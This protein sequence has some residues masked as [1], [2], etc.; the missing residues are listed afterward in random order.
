MNFI[1]QAFKGQFAFW[2]YIGFIGLFLIM[3]VGDTDNASLKIQSLIQQF[4]NNVTLLI[5][6]APF[7]ILLLFLF[8]W[9]KYIH[10]QPIKTLT[11]TRTKIDFKRILFA[12]CLW[13]GISLIMI[14]ISYI[15]D[16]ELIRLNFKLK[17]F[18]VLVLISVILIPIQ[19]SFEEYFFRA[20][21]IQGIG[22]VTKSKITALIV[23]SVIFGLLHLAN[24]EV[25]KMGYLIMVYYIG[26]GFFLGM[27]TLIDEGIELAIG[28]HTANNL[29]TALMITSN[30]T[31]F[32]T[33]SVFIDY[34]E[35]NLLTNT[36]LPVFIIYPCLFYIFAKKY[37]WSNYKEH[38]LGKVSAD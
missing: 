22:G 29:T 24:P 7:V 13:S 25:Q 12:F 32:Q 10:K 30:W 38:L 16:P 37:K 27:I 23:S 18:L 35:P 15:T 34:S 17:P 9:V 14:L 1:Q 21:I 33:N 19:T 8:I 20:Y 3:N 6:L 2:K 31:V 28:F 26:T 4:G 36:F 11:T 5:L